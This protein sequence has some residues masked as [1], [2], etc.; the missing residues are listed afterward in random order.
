ML[1]KMAIACESLYY[2]RIYAFEN[3][4]FFTRGALIA[5]VSY[6]NTIDYIRNK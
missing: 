2:V 1:E 6:I 5:L 3:Q 4:R